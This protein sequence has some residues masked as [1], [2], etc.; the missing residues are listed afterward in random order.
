MCSDS[1]DGGVHWA[2]S[3][4]AALYWRVK[5][6]APNAITCLRHSLKNSPEQMRVGAFHTIVVTLVFTIY[7]TCVNLNLALSAG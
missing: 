7:I 1:Q 4:V 6:D 2:L 3:T 5:G